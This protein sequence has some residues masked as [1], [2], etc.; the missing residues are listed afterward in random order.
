MKHIR[1][2]I[3]KIIDEMMLF[4]FSVGGQKIHIDYEHLD[5]GYRIAMESD[6]DPASREDLEHL[7]RYLNGPKDESILEY[8]WE[9]AGERESG[10]DSELYLV[11]QMIDKADIRV[12]E[13]KVTVVLEK[14]F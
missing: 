11:G 5:V 14:R 3:S 7:D 12:E 2:R 1:K 6:Y 10:R 4:F 8:Y 13:N 9:L